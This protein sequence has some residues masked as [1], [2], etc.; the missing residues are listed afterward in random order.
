MQTLTQVL[1][2]QGWDNQVVDD[3]QLARLLGGT[4]ARRYGLVNRA[5]Q[6]GE[7][8]R[9]KRGLYVMSPRFRQTLPHPFVV[10]QALLPASYVSF[11]SALA[12]HG[13]IPEAVYATTSVTPGRKS[14]NHEVAGYGQ[15]VFHPLALVSGYFLSGVQRVELAGQHCLL[16]SPLRALLDWVCLHKLTWQGLPALLDG[17]R[18]DEDG[19]YSVTRAEVLRLQPVY[20]HQRVQDYLQQLAGSLAAGPNPP[21]DA[22]WPQQ[23]TEVDCQH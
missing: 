11:E 22:A 4:D 5:L 1:L 10:A 13:W 17:M 21:G 12:Y 14:I 15:F 16:A 18:L 3:T 2:E 9:L 20:K 7:L 6:A 23:I 19:L 8:L